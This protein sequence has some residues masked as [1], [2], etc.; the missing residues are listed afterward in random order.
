M[1]DISVK[2][3]GTKRKR[4]RMRILCIG[5]LLPFAAIS[6]SSASLPEI[7]R[8]QTPVSASR[9]YCLGNVASLG[10]GLVRAPVESRTESSSHKGTYWT[11]WMRASAS[12]KYEISLPD[13]SARIFVNK[14]EV[15]SRPATMSKPVVVQIELLTNRFYAITVET[16]NSTDFSLPLQWRRPD[17]RH[18]TIPRA[19][20]YA[21]VATENVSENLRR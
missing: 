1:L 8:S 10:N 16:P 7:K 5:L 6:A 18:E 15:F 11:G 13:S 3:P 20:L 19:Y 17:G 2:S 4:H 9:N 14:Q 12:G 21:P